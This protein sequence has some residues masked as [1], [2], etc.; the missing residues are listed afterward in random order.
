MLF[1]IM[2]EINGELLERY[3]QGRCT[4]EERVLVAAWLDEGNFPHNLEQP[5]AGVGYEILLAVLQ[6][7]RPQDKSYQLARR[8]YMAIAAMLALTIGA[9]L[10]WNKPDLEVKQVVF[11]AP[12]GTPS[13][14]T[15]PDSSK[16][17]LQ[18]GS[19][20]SYAQ[21]F[22]AKERRVELL[23]G[24]VFFSVQHQDHQPFVVG[25]SGGEIKV[26]GTR[27]NVRNLKSSDKMQVVLTQGKISFRAG[28]GIAKVLK[29]GQ[30]L[31]FDKKAKK[32]LQTNMIDTVNVLAWKDG[33]LEFND[34]PMAEA[35]ELLSNRYGIPFKISC[36]LDLPI[37]GN[38]TNIPIVKTLSLIQRGSEYRF[39]NAGNAIEIYK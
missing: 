39:R 17:V 11:R 13:N 16:L 23:S 25:S 31:L 2:E 21:H 30:E 4:D 15:L 20:I 37:S 12:F 10:I 34:T 6:N 7:Q 3:V 27:F 35:L 18:P 9:F 26:L 19:V 14:L 29:P 36:K 1:I 8:G 32:V 22:N 33:A 38:F 5:K 28:G 24:E